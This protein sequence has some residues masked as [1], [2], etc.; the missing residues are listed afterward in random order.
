MNSNQGFGFLIGF[1]LGGVTGATI[2]LLWA[3]VSGEETR[4]QIRSGGVALKQRGEDFGNDKTQQAQ[5]MVKQGQKGVSDMQERTRLALEEQKTRLTEAIDT[6]KQA[7]SKR[8]DELVNRFEGN[9]APPA[10]MKA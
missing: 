7:A 6:G 9:K 5:N 4:E 2:A 1:L 8:K 3:P 10:D